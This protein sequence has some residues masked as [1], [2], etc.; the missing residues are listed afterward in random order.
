MF[1]DYI[2]IFRVLKK[3]IVTFHEFHYVNVDI[4]RIF[5]TCGFQQDSSFLC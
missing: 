1:S 3:C 2:Y 4:H 5:S